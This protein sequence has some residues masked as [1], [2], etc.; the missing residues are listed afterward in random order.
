MVMNR[1]LSTLEL[2]KILKQ[3]TGQAYRKPESLR[4]GR[5]MRREQSETKA[6]DEGIQHDVP[7]D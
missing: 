6:E 1:V 2:G 7:P 3:R 5:R 4:I